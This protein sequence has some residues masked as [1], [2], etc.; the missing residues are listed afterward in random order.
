[1]SGSPVNDNSPTSPTESPLNVRT[2][3]PIPMLP[4][5]RLSAV[6]APP[7]PQFQTIRNMWVSSKGKGR[8]ME[9][10]LQPLR[11]TIEIATNDGWIDM[12]NLWFI[13]SVNTANGMT[14]SFQYH[15]TQADLFQGNLS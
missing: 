14:Q 8:P 2:T 15:G 1:M 4:V 3:R 6:K 10:Q 13:E 12:S 11:T 7:R 5:A 9:E